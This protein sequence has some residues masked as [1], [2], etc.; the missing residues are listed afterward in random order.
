V[1]DCVSRL[2]NGCGDTPVAVTTLVT[3]E[4][5]SDRVLELLML[6]ARL[7]RLELI[8]ERATRQPGE[9]KQARKRVLLP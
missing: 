3:G 9:R 2:P 5:G 1:I 6:I 7:P 8:V 4:N